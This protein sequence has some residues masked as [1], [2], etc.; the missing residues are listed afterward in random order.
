[1]WQK[2]WRYLC[3]F[4]LS[5]FSLLFTL[6][7]S[8][9]ITSTTQSSSMQQLAIELPGTKS[10]TILIDNQGKLLKRAL[11]SSSDGSISLSIEPGT[12]LLDENKTPLRSI[13]AAIDP[14]IPVPPKDAD[15]I[16]TIYDIQPQG[17]IINPSLSLTLKYDQSALAQGTNENNLWVYNYTGT[18]WEMVRYKNIDTGANRVT[19]TISRL[20]KYS[21]LAP[22][23]PVA[24]PVSP[25]QPSLTSITIIEA[26][27]NG[28]P[29][30]AEFGRGTCIPCKQMK[31]ILENLAVEYEDR[32]N[33]PIVSIDD[34]RELTNYYKIMGI[35]TQ[36]VFDSNGK[37]VFRHIGFWPKDQII[38]Q[39]S[40]LGIK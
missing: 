29:T 34:Y 28:K 10:N 39:L 12:T 31:P 25:A 4:I 9:G 24:T 1:M 2:R 20:G 26:L 23:K 3:V 33:V 21:V 7:C 19:T 40:K 36:I 6:S 8:S 32:L 37:E 15:I 14:I 5:V 17:A 16:G 22:I 30:L 35:P 18:S 13:K 38:P 27:K 11:I